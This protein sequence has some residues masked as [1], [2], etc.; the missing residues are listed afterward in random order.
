[1]INRIARK[2]SYWCME[3]LQLKKE[4]QEVVQYGTEVFLDGL[5]KILVLIFVGICV[6][7][8]Q[9][10]VLALLGFC[11]LRYWAGGMHCKTS[12]GCLGTMIAI[13]LVSVYAA[14]YF[15]AAPDWIVL[16]TLIL[17]YIILYFMAPGQTKRNPIC[18]YTTYFRK[19]VGAFLWLALEY[20]VI[21]VMR[22][23]VARWILIISILFE[24]F[25]ILP[26]RKNEN[27]QRRFFYDKQKL[28]ED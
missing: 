11:S 26:C 3:K 28:G 22:D 5:L 15:T 18:D 25:S 2:I 13:C 9:E 1:M 8:L 4:E 19:R 24:I 21:Y 7:R 12:L 27:F 16:F 10:V 17:E 6:G 20:I 23:K 14:P